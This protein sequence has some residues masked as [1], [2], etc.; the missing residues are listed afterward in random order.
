MDAALL[1]CPVSHLPLHA[2]APALVEHLRTLTRQRALRNEYAQVIAEDF[3]DAWVG[4]D[5]QRAWLVREG[6]ADFRPGQ[7]VLLAAGEAAGA[8][9]GER[10]PR[11][12]EDPAP[13]PR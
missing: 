1:A 4:A 6:L 9:E 7:A 5:G 10:D 11:G 2:A 3:S 13:R 12:P 8:L